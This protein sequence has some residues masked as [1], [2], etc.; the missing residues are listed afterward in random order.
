MPQGLE[1]W[2]VHILASSPQTIQ[3]VVNNF[4]GLAFQYDS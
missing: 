4:N 2:T 3:T 1:Y